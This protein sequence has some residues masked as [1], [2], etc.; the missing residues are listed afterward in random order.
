[1]A[2]WRIIEGDCVE[3]MAAMEECSVD[4]VVC[5]PPYGFSFM[6]K[7]W[8]TF[9][10][11]TMAERVGT[12]NGNGPPSD[13]RDGRHKGRTASAFA[14]PGGEAGA[15]DFSLKG[16]AAFQ[17]WSEQW[18]SE[19]LRV[20]K[21]GGHLLAF[22]GTR[23][24]HRLACAVED[25]GFE[26]R[27]TICWLYGSGFPKSLNLDGDHE[28]W[29]TAL[30]PAHEP[31]VVARKPLVGTVAANVLE[32]GT[33]ALN[34]DGCRIGNTAADREAAMKSMSGE[35]MWRRAGATG[36][37]T[38]DAGC[39][40][41]P[42][43]H[44]GGRWPANVVL[45]PEAAD[46]LDA[47]TGDLGL[48]TGTAAGGDRERTFSGGP[49]IGDGRLTG[50]GDSGGASRFF[51]VAKASRAERNAGLGGFEVRVRPITDGHGRGPLNTSKATEDGLREN[52]PTA[53]HHPTVKPIALMRWLVRLV[54]PP[55][56]LALHRQRHNGLRCGARG[57]PVRRHRTRV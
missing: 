6:G 44:D 23:T 17:Q 21:P 26:I 42:A 51:Y 32:H 47:Q 22:G 36:A 24:Y 7:A 30:K 11:R 41:E 50:Y 34:V 35:R 43:M 1:V 49:L 19:A 15:Y 14:N 55:D 8:D 38:F 53:N 9:D 40:A 46:M 13:V 5:D 16:N 12:R 48:S 39:A 57:V 29:G 28:G 56:G 37:A 31:I 52:R 18:A 3:A 33:G 45:D 2:S 25:A 54:T 20:L 27:D 4:A 10:P